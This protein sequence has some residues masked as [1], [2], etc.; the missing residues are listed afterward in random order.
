MRV[1]L[2]R[3]QGSSESIKRQSREA[4]HRMRG[5]IRRNREPISRPRTSA[6][7]TRNRTLAVSKAAGSASAAAAA[8]VAA[9]VAA[10]FSLRCSRAS[11]RSDFIF[12]IFSR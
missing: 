7:S 11:V 6:P 3:N 1:A 8:A 10:A 5:A 2:R 12:A 4:K 9:S